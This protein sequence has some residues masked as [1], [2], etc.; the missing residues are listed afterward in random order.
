MKLSTEA[1]VVFGSLFQHGCDEVIF[2]SPWRI[3][4]NTK[5]GLD[6]LVENHILEVEIKGSERYGVLLYSTTLRSKNVE[7]IEPEF[8]ANN[9]FPVTDNS[10]EKPDD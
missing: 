5:L 2:K 3:H 6:E 1:K 8:I 10:I 7:Y 9:N 4:P